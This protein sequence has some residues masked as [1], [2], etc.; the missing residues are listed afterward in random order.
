MAQPRVGLRGRP[1][2][3]VRRDSVK[4]LSYTSAASYTGAAWHA[5]IAEGSPEILKP[6]VEVNHE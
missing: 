5:N 4:R 3:G 1:V 2:W 6:D